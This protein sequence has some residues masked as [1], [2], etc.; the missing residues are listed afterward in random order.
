MR[1]NGPVNK[2]AA[3]ASARVASIVEHRS[4]PA[5]VL[6]LQLADRH[7]VDPEFSDALAQSLRDDPALIERWQ[8]WSEDQRSMPSA[9]V[10]ATEVGWFDG[11]RSNVRTHPDRSA[12]VADFIQR[13]AAW[14]A[15]REVLKVEGSAQRPL[16]KP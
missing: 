8:A 11:A 16:D 12:A 1:E 4:S 2:D 13:L 6:L 10:Q 3:T 5:F 14:L 7:F 9:Y 15:R